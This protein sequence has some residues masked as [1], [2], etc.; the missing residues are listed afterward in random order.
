MKQKLEMT[1]ESSR[2]SFLGNRSDCP[3]TQF[4]IVLWDCAK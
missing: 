1:S 4:T 3:L 2:V